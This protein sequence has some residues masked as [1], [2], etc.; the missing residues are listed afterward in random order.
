MNFTQIPV[1]FNRNFVPENMGLYRGVK[2][3]RDS[4]I[5]VVYYIGPVLIDE[6]TYCKYSDFLP[7]FIEVI[8][9]PNEGDVHVMYVQSTIRTRGLGTFLVC[10]GV[11]TGF[12]YGVHKVGLD[13][14]SVNFREEDNIY[15]KLG[16]TYVAEYGPEMVGTTRGIY[17]IWPSIVAKY[18][19]FDQEFSVVDAFGIVS[20][21][22][23]RV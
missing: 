6:N 2:Y 3:I 17:E 14:N 1:T 18:R 20:P 22:S 5:K 7:G 16:F 12:L 9:D 21:D 8:I 23:I 10:A 13:D 4:C 11:L 19:Y 15:V